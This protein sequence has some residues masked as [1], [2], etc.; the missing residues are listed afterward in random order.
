MKVFP[1]Q[2]FASLLEKDAAKRGIQATA[3]NLKEYDPED[4]LPSE[5]SST[6]EIPLYLFFVKKIP[7]L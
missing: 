6:P 1:F 4:S 3:V 5:V 2:H 7:E